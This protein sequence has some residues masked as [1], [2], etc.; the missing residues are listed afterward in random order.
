MTPVEQIFLVH[1]LLSGARVPVTRAQ[2]EERLECS[3]A[4]ALRAL[5][6]LR[7]LFDAPIHYY[8]FEVHERGVR[9]WWTIR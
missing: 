5:N 8:G 3:R 4:T 9:P 6:R 7:T 1:R 2:I